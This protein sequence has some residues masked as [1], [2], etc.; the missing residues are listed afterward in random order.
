MSDDGLTRQVREA[1]TGKATQHDRVQAVVALIRER[2]EV[3]FEAY[4]MHT[5]VE[6]EQVEAYGMRLGLDA[7]GDACHR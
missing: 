2:D 3:I 6:V 7:N 1:L 5:R 4:P